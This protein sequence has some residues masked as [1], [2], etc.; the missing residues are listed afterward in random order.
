MPAVPPGHHAD[1]AQQHQRESPGDTRL[2]HQPGRHQQQAGAEDDAR[3]LQQP[4]GVHR[5]APAVERQPV[6]HGVIDRAPE[7]GAHEQIAVDGNQRRQPPI[8]REVAADAA[9]EI[10]QSDHGASARGRNS[11]ASVA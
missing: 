9:Q 7:H 8:G 10:A 5:I 11:A 2:E 3:D 1:G 4:D 6:V